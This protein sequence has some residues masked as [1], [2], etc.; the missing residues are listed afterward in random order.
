MSYP[1]GSWVMIDRL[2]DEPVIAFVYLDP[3]AGPSAK[4]GL[5][6]QHDLAQMPSRTVRL[7]PQVAMRELSASEISARRLPSR[8]DWITHYGPQPDPQA[9]WHKDPLLAGKFHPQYPDDIQSFVHDGDPRRQRRGPELCWVRILKIDRAPTRQVSADY[10]PSR[11]VYIGELLNQ[12][13]TL[14]SVKKGDRLKLISVHGLPHPLHVTDEYL[15]EREDWRI[16]P[17]DR[18]GASETFDPPSVMARVRFP[19]MPEGAVLE[20]FTSICSHCGG[21][22]QLSHV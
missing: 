12:P 1:F 15:A 18:C 10:E 3:H 8:P 4:G 9:A 19:N 7:T 11:H 21:V 2:P 17:C 22:Q 14:T 13:H 16:T 5:A 20:A 6:S